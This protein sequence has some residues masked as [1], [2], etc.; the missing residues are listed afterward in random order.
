MSRF[1]DMID[2]YKFGILAAL[3]V[4]IGIFMYLQLDSYDHIFEISPFHDGSYVDI[5]DED[6]KVDHNN[7]LVP[8]DF[9]P[10][11][12]R[13]MVTDA[14][15]DR[16]E[17]MTD[18]SEYQSSSDV[19][20]SVYDLEQQMYNDAGGDKDRERIKQN[21]DKRNESSTT[22]STDP[23]NTQ[24]S[25]AS[26]PNKYAGATL[27]DFDLKNRTPYQNNSWYIRNPGYTSLGSGK[28]VV[29]IIVN[30]NGNVI[31][32]VINSARSAGSTERMREQAL[33]YAKMSR[34]NYSSS[35]PKTQKGTIQ[36]IFDAR[37]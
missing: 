12:I 28:V 6:I 22:T 17:S 27:V 33:K 35:A 20:K 25:G 7:V 34:F 10:G 36:Y 1:F 29:D 37:K 11:R 26:S 2:K 8:S 30:Q 31:S 16:P 32:A 15:D 24:E 14:N 19:Q 21:W 5:P 4:Y 3:T 9:Q 18:Y 23:K 13:N